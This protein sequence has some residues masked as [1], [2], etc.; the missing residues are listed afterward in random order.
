MSCGICQDEV[1][2]DRSVAL[3]CHPSH[4]FCR[5]CID[6]YVQLNFA[7]AQSF[8]CPYCRRACRNDR[9][10]A[11]DGPIDVSVEELQNQWAEGNREEEPSQFP[12]YSLVQPW[13]YPQSL[14]AES[15]VYNFALMPG[16]YQP[17]GSVNFSRASSVILAQNWNMQRTFD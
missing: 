2:A 12:Y 14:P 10:I 15:G 11:E 17:S 7:A 6:T 9:P 4:V 16:S 3:E 5:S 8:P 1:S 13:P